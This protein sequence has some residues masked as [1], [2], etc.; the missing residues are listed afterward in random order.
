MEIKTHAS[1]NRSLCGEP[2]H[3][4]PGHALVRLVAASDMAADSRGLVHGGFVFG[5]ADYAAMLAVNHPNVVLGQSEAK[6]LKPVRVG[7]ILEAR[8]EVTVVESGR[9]RRV[10]VKV[11]RNDEVVMTGA[12]ACY[13]LEHHVLDA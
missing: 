5:L 1:I 2:M 7:D 9:K 11:S 13:V 3:L 8:A 6:F 12:F 4:E 10:E